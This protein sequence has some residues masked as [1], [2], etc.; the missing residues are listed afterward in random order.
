MLWVKHVSFQ[1]QALLSLSNHCVSADHLTGGAER[2]DD[3]VLSVAEL[4]KSDFCRTESQ[5]NVK[6][7]WAEW[8]WHHCVHAQHWN[9]EVS[10]RL[11]MWQSTCR[12][13]TT[14]A[15][16][17]ERQDWLFYYLCFSSPFF[18]FVLLFLSLSFL[19]LSVGSQEKS[20]DPSSLRQRSSVTA[21]SVHTSSKS[22]SRKHF[23]FNL[24]GSC[25]CNGFQFHAQSSTLQ[26]IFSS[27]LH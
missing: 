4:A 9:T 22:L 10:T 24:L 18:S 2:C 17:R 16:G 23:C 21:G 13:H 25:Q 3:N 26:F 8:N 7:E 12:A 19:W 20:V 15:F 6:N 11:Q 5:V 27:D 1:E 14:L